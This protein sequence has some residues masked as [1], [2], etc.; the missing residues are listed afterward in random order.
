M[1]LSIEGMMEIIGYLQQ[2]AVL[3]IIGKDA[4]IFL[5]GQLTADL[6]LANGVGTLSA[7]CNQ[8]GRVLAVFSIFYCCDAYYLLLP[9][10]IIGA[11]RMR[12]KQFAL[13]MQIEFD[14]LST[15]HVLALTDSQT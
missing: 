12:L 13:R 7:Y 3:R 2:L 1:S 8:Q 9:T 15:S 5:Q 4:S 6:R 11:V 14:D 10:E